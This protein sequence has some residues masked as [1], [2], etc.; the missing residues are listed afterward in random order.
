MKDTKDGYLRTDC[1]VVRKSLEISNKV[2]S[3]ISYLGTGCLVGGKAGP[4]VTLR[5]R[6]PRRRLIRSTLGTYIPCVIYRA[7]LWR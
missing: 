7:Y 1:R 2:R 4:G 6:S 5:P 3:R